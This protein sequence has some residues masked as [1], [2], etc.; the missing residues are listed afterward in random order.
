M[1]DLSTTALPQLPRWQPA[2]AVRPAMS[3]A[4][5][6]WVASC[7]SLTERLIAAAGERPFRVRLLDQRI[8]RPRIDEAQALGL[9]PGR[10]AWLRE[11]ALC[12][13]ERPWVVARS[14][15][16]LSQLRGQRLGQLGERSLGSWLFRQPGLERGP[17]DV[18]RHPV[19]LPIAQISPALWARRSVFR[20]R[21]FAVLVQ[22]GFLAGM[23]DELG[24][25]TR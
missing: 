5:W 17:I 13:A 21:R 22:E 12:V 19:L 24:L 11:V 23:A 6:Q 20:H 1:R 3:P 4:W 15:A 18:T 14:V 2:A 16:P 25:P 9:A 7:D 10:H 8:G